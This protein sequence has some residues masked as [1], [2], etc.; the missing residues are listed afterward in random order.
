MAL[1]KDKLQKGLGL[2][3]TL[4]I[5]LSTGSLALCIFNMKFTMFVLLGIAFAYIILHPQI[6]RKQF[7]TLL[8]VLGVVLFNSVLNIK[9]LELNDDIVILLIQ[10]FSIAT[11]SS[12]ITRRTF[13]TNYCKVLF[14]L[15]ILSLAC[16]SVS[17]IGISLPGT[18]EIWFKNKF[19]IY[20]FYHTLGRWYIF[21]RNAGIFWESPAFAIFINIAVAFV[22]LADVNISPKKRTTY[23]IVYSITLFSTLAIT[24]Y[25]EF[26]FVLMAIVFQKSN[27]KTINE[28]KEERSTRYLVGLVVF[29]V[30]VVFLV[31]ENSTHMI[32]DK[33]V[34][35]QGSFTERS[36][37]TLQAIRI[38]L[39]RPLTGFGLFNSYTEEVL[40]AVKVTDNSN[41]FSAMLM[42]LG[43]P[44]FLAYLWQFLRGIRQYFNSSIV[45]ILFLYGTFIVFLNSEQIAKMTLFLFFL[46]PLCSGNE[47][48]PHRII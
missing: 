7:C 8:G 38:G 36:N 37:D 15:C 23:F 4:W 29:V 40:N 26:F 6:G 35:R 18:R 19:Y 42:Y 2:F 34:H 33:I 22:M 3:A 41:S 31:R 20:T 17:E 45:S 48:N 10:L 24:G 25:I 16:F 46:F 32:R 30:I 27:R 21:H 12:N 44:F 39:E 13:T 14:L 5:I 9:F 28:E 1:S 47:E 43:V 11:I